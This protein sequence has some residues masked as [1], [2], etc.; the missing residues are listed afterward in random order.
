M[1]TR[2]PA[3]A[4]SFFKV[5]AP[6]LPFST[7]RPPHRRVRYNKYDDMIM[8]AIENSRGIE[9]DVSIR[10]L[11]ATID[12]ATDEL[13][14]MKLEVP[15]LWV[16]TYDKIRERQKQCLSLSD[17]CELAAE[18]GLP[19]AG[20]KLMP[21][22]RSRRHLA[23]IAAFATDASPL[24]CVAFFRSSAV[25]EVVCVC[26]CSTLSLCVARRGQDAFRMSV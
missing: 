13:P 20:L 6:S 26:L 1:R 24:S 25:H 10:N 17:V 3:A 14:C 7:L 4:A 9:G 19:H 2:A 22:V 15:K 12:A 16:L 11:A 5:S 21:E 23:L 18:C 8:H